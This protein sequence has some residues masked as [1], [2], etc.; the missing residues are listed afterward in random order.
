MHNYQSNH[1]NAE[2]TIGEPHGATVT[3]R[4]GEHS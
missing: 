1:T 2:A 4:E 3:N